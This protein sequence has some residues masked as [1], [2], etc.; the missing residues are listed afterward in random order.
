MCSE[1]QAFAPG[2]VPEAA[3]PA[4][5]GAS[6]VPGD[7]AK[8]CGPAVPRWPHCCP[9][10]TPIWSVKDEAEDSSSRPQAG[11]PPVVWGQASSPKGGAAPAP[12]APNEEAQKAR[13]AQF[14][15]ELGVRERVAPGKGILWAE[16]LRSSWVHWWPLQGQEE[17][18]SVGQGTEPC[19]KG[20]EG[21]EHGKKHTGH[22]PQ[23]AAQ[24]GSKPSPCISHLH[25]SESPDT[26]P[27]W[28]FHRSVQ[29]WEGPTCHPGHQPL[30][31]APC[32]TGSRLTR[33]SSSPSTAK[34]LQHLQSQLS[35]RHWADD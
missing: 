30:L 35:L 28:P 20:Q 1:A 2:V 22:R 13:K 8:P 14:P 27:A 4:G 5:S 23:V 10:L 24:E 26:S 19:P 7:A 33:L 9:F 25:K 15:R 31:G 34:S 17:M 18:E 11:L 6:P 12:F 29:T 21:T 32:P 16:L 3:S